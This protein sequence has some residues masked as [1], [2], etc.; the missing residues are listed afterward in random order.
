MGSTEYRVVDVD[1]H[2]L[3]DLEG[4]AEYFSEPFRAEVLERDR[5]EYALDRLLPST[6]GDRFMGGRIRRNTEGE[7]DFLR[8]ASDPE[9]VPGIMDFV[10]LDSILLIPQRLLAFS[11][12]KADDERMVEVANGY[13]DYMLEEV[14]DPYDDIYTTIVAPYQDP[15]ASVELIERVGDESGIVGVCLVTGGAEPP[16][17]HHRYDPIYEAAESEG[18]PVVFHTGGSG[19]DEYHVRGYESELATHTLG[20]LVSN[21]S[22]IT[23]VVVQG[24]PEK[25]PDLDIVFQESGLS[26][27]PMLATRLDAEY[28]KR[29]SEA[30]LLEKMPSEYMTDFYY[31]TQP[32]EDDVAWLEHVIDYIGPKQIMYA[33]DYPHWDYDEPHV[34]T[35]LSFLDS[36]EKRS[37]LGDNATEVFSI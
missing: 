16:L 33:S 4:I 12:I 6:S 5:P 15:E 23:S 29:Q 34:I 31:G 11:G 19:L 26:Y 24:I 30:P 8:L 18:L 25:F 2:F 21:M 1:A 13:A 27:V 10:G 20:F 28:M 3:E 37:V 7:T 22:Q 9:D 35:D 36:A 17:G 14:I 32:L